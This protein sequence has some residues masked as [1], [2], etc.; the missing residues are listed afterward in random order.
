M[1]SNL[2]KLIFNHGSGLQGRTLS[3]AAAVRTLARLS[4]QDSIPCLLG[5]DVD[6]V[7]EACVPD[8]SKKLQDKEESW[9]LSELLDSLTSTLSCSAHAVCNISSWLYSVL[10]TVKFYAEFPPSG[11]QTRPDEPGPADRPA[12]EA[13]IILLMLLHQ[14]LH[15][16]LLK[17]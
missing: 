4:S 11:T 14:W 2:S 10:I 5:V 1:L 9:K 17:H 6:A 13:F 3:W 16:A 15:N 12:G 8:F 7:K